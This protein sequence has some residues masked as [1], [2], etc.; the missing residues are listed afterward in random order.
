L[1]K[2]SDKKIIKNGEIC[3][4]FIELLLWLQIQRVKR[5]QMFQGFW[6]S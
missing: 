2:L 4:R 5:L 1:V 6:F 3:K